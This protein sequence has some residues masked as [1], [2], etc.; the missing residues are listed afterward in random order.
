MYDVVDG[1]VEIDG[2]D[3]RQINI[4]HL[5][6]HIAFVEQMPKLFNLTI[7]ENI[8][9][10]RPTATKEEIIQAAKRANIHDSIEALPKV[11]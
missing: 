2:Y 8:S 10:G 5:R 1:S 3:I 4:S 11:T 7:A 6:S 9:Y